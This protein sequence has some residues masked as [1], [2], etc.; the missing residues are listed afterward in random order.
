MIAQLL[1]RGFMLEQAQAVLDQLA[2]MAKSER[3]IELAEDLR[4]TSSDYENLK[5]D[6][7]AE[8]LD[9]LAKSI[10]REEASSSGQ[11]GYEPEPPDRR[12]E[13]VAPLDDFSFLS[14]DPAMSNLQSALELAIVDKEGDLLAEGEPSDIRRESPEDPVAV[15]DRSIVG[16]KPFRDAN[17][18]RVFDKFSVLDPGWVSSLFAMGIRRLRK[19]HPF[20]NAQPSDVRISETARIVLV[21]DWG[22]GLPRAQRVS[23]QMRRE[24]AAA[25]AD[26]RE[27]HVIHLGD[28]Y[29]SGWDYEYKR[30]FLGY[31]PVSLSDAERIGSWTLNGNHDMYSGG[32]AY[33]KTA[34]GDSRFRPYHRGSSYFRLHSSRW[35]LLGLD[36]AYEDHG[37]AGDQAAWA[38]AHVG[39]PAHHER[40]T[41][42]LSHHQVFSAY[43]GDS[44]SELRRKIAP[45]LITGNIYG[46]F[47][48]HEHRCVHFDPYD[49]VQKARCIGHGGVPVYMTH[50]A[51]PVPF[52]GNWES[53]SSFVRGLE[54]WALFGFAVLDLQ[55]ESALVRYL[56]ENGSEQKREIL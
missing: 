11:P 8:A 54:R 49:F 56:D 33:F 36:S 38:V 2:A 25:R 24:I 50:G 1:H 6:D 32:H 48:G 31:W 21:G 7:I 34:L 18:R 44:R 42:L 28:V 10:S 4:S 47:W 52:P 40:K 53:R 26:G 12:G 29:Y 41:L 39:G 23:D 22:S 19:R 16:V 35:Q 15:T 20:P 13:E 45:A 43:E 17:G 30:R 51:S 27:V 37:L 14:R 46:W 9:H 55:E 3:E 5:R